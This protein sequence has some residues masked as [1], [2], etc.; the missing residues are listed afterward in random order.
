MNTDNIKSDLTVVQLADMG[1]YDTDKLM[2]MR[3]KLSAILGDI[4]IVPQD[5]TL[6]QHCT[7]GALRSLDEVIKDYITK[8]I[9]DSAV[10]DDET[11]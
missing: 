8:A 9:V 7:V 10:D 5:I 11:E 2:E 3:D 1:S 6:L 4:I